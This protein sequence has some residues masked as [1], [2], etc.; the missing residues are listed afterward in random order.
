MADYSLADIAA[1]G[2]HSAGGAGTG[3]L[4]GGVG[5]ITGYDEP[6]VGVGYY[7]D[8]DIS[9]LKYNTPE[10]FKEL[11]QIDP[12]YQGF[13]NQ[14]GTEGII[15]NTRFTLSDFAA[16]TSHTVNWVIVFEDGIQGIA[17][18]NIQMAKD[19]GNDAQFKDDLTIFIDRS[20]A[21]R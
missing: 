3:L 1:L 6:I 9:T 4:G 18:W 2:G 10:Y 13:I 21:S 7:I 12:N 15:A 8:G 14:Y 11:V 19:F 5:F 17:K 16:N 20:G